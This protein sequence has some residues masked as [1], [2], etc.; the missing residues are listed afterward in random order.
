MK[1]NRKGKVL[2]YIIDN[3]QSMINKGF[4]PQEIFTEKGKVLKYTMTSKGKKI[5][6]KLKPEP[7]PDEIVNTIID[8]GNEGLINK[9]IA[10][11]V[12]KD[13]GDEIFIKN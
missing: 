8:M 1:I 9:K 12:I 13:I 10:Y 3:F 6:K 7:T 2:L 4:F 11:D 5:L